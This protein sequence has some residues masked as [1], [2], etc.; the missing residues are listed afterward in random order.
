VICSI[1]QKGRSS[2]TLE[3]DNLA[4]EMSNHKQYLA[5]EFQLLKCRLSSCMVV[6]ESKNKRAKSQ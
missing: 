1:W 3:Y 4:E 2:K 6:P 5:S